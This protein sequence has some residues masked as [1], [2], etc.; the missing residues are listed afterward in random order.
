MINGVPRN[1]D[2]FESLG[3]EPVRFV[4]ILVDGT[5]DHR[6]VRPGELN[7]CRATLVEGDVELVNKSRDLRAAAD[8]PAVTEGVGD[9]IDEEN[10]SPIERQTVDNGIEGAI[11]QLVEIEGRAEGAAEL[12]QGGQFAEAALELGPRQG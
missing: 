10:E 1:E 7:E 6:T 11:E 4:R 3:E 12:V 5:E 8:R 2:T 9:R